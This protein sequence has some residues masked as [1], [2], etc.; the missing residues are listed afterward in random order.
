M[1]HEEAHDQGNRSVPKR[2]AASLPPE[3]AMIELPRSAF[4]RKKAADTTAEAALCRL[5][6]FHAALQSAELTVIP[7][8]S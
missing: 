6:F 4:P 3:A 7:R 1:I 2:F 5:R 8:G